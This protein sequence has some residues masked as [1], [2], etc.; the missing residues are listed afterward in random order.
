MRSPAS[1]K[2][3]CKLVQPRSLR[4]LQQQQRRELPQP[5]SQRQLQ[6]QQQ[7]ECSNYCSQL[8]CEMPNCCNPKIGASMF[9]DEHQHTDVCAQDANVNPP[10]ANVD[11]PHVN[12]NSPHANVD[13]PHANVDSPHVNVNPPHVNVDSPHVNVDPQQDVT[14]IRPIPMFARESVSGRATGIPNAPH[15]NH[16]VHDSV[17]RQLYDLLSRGEEVRLDRITYDDRTPTSGNCRHDAQM[18]GNNKGQTTFATV[19]YDVQPPRYNS[20]HFVMPACEY[21]PQPPPYNSTHFVLPAS[22]YVPQPPLYNNAHC[23]P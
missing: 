7:R 1:M 21:A 12:V 15:N 6:Q 8:I 20:T 4:Q 17:R 3:R 16:H 19:N 23:Y 9:C 22:E 11:S 14:S 10:H 5:R 2:R 18:I 13:S